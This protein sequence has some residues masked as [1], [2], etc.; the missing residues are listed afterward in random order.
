M[1]RTLAASAVVI[2]IGL[3]FSGSGVAAAT[4]AG[5]STGTTPSVQF[6]CERWG[7]SG[8]VDERAPVRTGMSASAPIAYYVSKG[9]EIFAH[10][11]CI[12]SKGNAW[13]ELS[14]NLSSGKFLYSGHV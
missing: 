1:R 8:I 2:S 9:E 7:R 13:Y 14:G 3:A 4:S 12:N 6:D 5:T 10:Y 11:R